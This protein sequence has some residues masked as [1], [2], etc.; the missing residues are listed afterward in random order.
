MFRADKGVRPKTNK[1]KLTKHI[2]VRKQAR[3]HEEERDERD[4]KRFS[5]RFSGHGVLL[6]WVN[7]K[8]PQ[9]LRE[10]T[11][12]SGYR[13]CSAQFASSH[14]LESLDQLHTYI[15]LVLFFSPVTQR[16]GLMV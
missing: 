2:Q 3:R 16:G 11:T 8:L 4:H 10:R 15:L 9:I 1:M 6:P 13:S 12:G 7:T 5:A 14:H